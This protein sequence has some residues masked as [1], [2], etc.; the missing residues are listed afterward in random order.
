MKASSVQDTGRM[1]WLDIA[2]AAGICL[3]VFGHLVTDDFIK[4]ILWTFHVPLFFFLSGYLSRATDAHAFARRIGLRL[5]V[6][7][8]AVY[9]LLTLLMLRTLDWQVLAPGLR[10]MF[11]GS[12]S[13]PQFIFAPLWF[14]PA[15]VTVEILVFA[16]ARTTW[17]LYPLALG[18]SLWLYHHGRVDEFMSVDLALLGLNYF[19]L[20]MWARSSGVLQR[21]QAAPMAGGV[22]AGITLAILIDLALAGNVWFTGPSYARSLLGGVAGIAMTVACAQGL[23]RGALLNN[24]LV[25][26][27]SSHTLFILCFHGISNNYAV[28]WLSLAGADVT[29]TPALMGAAALSVTLLLPFAWMVERWAPWVIGVP[30]RPRAAGIGM[31]LAGV[32]AK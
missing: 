6:P 32:A 30:G 19:V 11:Y 9:V 27:I 16:M 12:H 1:A 29:R 23:Q 28:Y 4:K 20:G 8:V 31:A 5:I 15:L 14:L 2:K 21:L 10:G 18:A 3:I 26:F 17:M 13:Y 22:V 24:R 25:R 7:Y